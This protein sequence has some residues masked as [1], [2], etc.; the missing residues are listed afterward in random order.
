MFPPSGR[1]LIQL[2]DLD[3]GLVDAE[4]D[5]PVLRDENFPATLAKP[6]RLQLATALP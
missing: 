3:L 1:L 5:S 2:D 4:R 6:M